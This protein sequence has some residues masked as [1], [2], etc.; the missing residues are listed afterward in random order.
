MGWEVAPD[1]FLVGKRRWMPH[2]RFQPTKK[3]EDAFRL[4]EQAGPEEYAMGRKGREQFWAW[5]KIGGTIG[6]A[7]AG[8]KPQSITLA[9]AQ[10][11]GIDARQ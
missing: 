9:V 8:S 5:V 2:W 1:R 4:L 10:A 11:L 3:L 6:E 7:R